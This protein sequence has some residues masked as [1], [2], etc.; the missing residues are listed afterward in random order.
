MAD[1][2]ITDKL[3]YA[4]RISKTNLK[5]YTGYKV[6]EVTAEN[7]VL[8]GRKGDK[9]QIPVDTIITAIGLSPNNCLYNELV[10]NTGLE[11]YKIGDAVAA[12]KIFDAIHTAYKLALNI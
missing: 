4:E 6:V 5:I 10:V 1:V 7:V 9:K 11:V 12:G 2:A 8:S 3:A